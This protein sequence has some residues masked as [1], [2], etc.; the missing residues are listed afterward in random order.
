MPFTMPPDAYLS[1]LRLRVRDLGKQRGFWHD[2]IGLRIAS[3]ESGAVHLRPESGS[4][5]LILEEDGEAPFRPERSIGLYHVALLL[6]GRAELAALIRRLL[7]AKYGGFEGASDHGVSEAFYLHDPEGNGLEL[8]RD[9]ERS[10]WPPADD[11]VAMYTKRLDVEELLSTASTSAPTDPKTRIG[12]M[13]VHVASLPE[14][15]RFYAGTLGLDVT[16]RGYQGALFFAT[17]GYHHHVGANIWAGAHRPP[18]GATGLIEYGWAL[19]ADALEALRLS[20][21]PEAAAEAALPGGE[22]LRLSDPS[23]AHVFLQPAEA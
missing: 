13:H 18:A 20:L 17:G 7:E 4:F 10:E 19:P 15:E 1:E 16:Q 5:R 8:Y 14:A 9:R 12:H 21:G 2:L 11:G 3:E 6:P 23:G 22:G